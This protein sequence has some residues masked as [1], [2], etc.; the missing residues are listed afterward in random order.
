MSGRDN[1]Y[2]SVIQYYCNEPFYAFFGGVNGEITT[3]QFSISKACFDHG[4]LNVPFKVFSFSDS[5]QPLALLQ[6]SNKY[7]FYFHSSVNFIC[8]SDRKW[9]SQNDIV[10]IP[11][12]LPGNYFL[13]RQ[14]KIVSKVEKFCKTYWPRGVRSQQQK[15][16]FN[17]PVALHDPVK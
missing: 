17:F 13:Q 11:K 7:M 14:D 6:L 5:L 2:Q 10:P 8:E 4:L 1:Q 3:F 15:D 12:C 9:R 16:G